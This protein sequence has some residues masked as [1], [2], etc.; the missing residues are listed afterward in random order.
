[1]PKLMR[2]TPVIATISPRVNLTRRQGLVLHWLAEGETNQEIANILN[3][4][5]HNAKNHLR[6]IFRRL[7][8]CRRTAAAACAYGVDLDEAEALRG[9]V[10]P[11]ASS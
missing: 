5:F 2:A 3:G 9:V 6:K 11:T 4:S 1:M 10:P 7:N 8:V